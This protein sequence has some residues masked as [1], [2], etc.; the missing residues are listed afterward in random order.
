[1]FS[2]VNESKVLVKVLRPRTRPCL[3]NP[4]L[5][6]SGDQ[7]H[8]GDTEN[9]E[10]SQIRSPC[11][12]CLRGEILCVQIHQTQPTVIITDRRKPTPYQM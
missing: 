8:H 11:S 5:K 4:F 1:M 12:P 10:K 7:I 2:L 9:T 6:K 3:M